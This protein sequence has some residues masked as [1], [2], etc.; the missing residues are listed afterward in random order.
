MSQNY[1][2]Q[3]NGAYE[4][5]LTGKKKRLEAEREQTLSDLAAQEAAAGVRARQAADQ[6]AAAHAKEQAAWNEVQTAQGLTSG[7]RGQARLVMDNRLQADLAAIGRAKDAETAELERKRQAAVRD[8]AAALE[9]AQAESDYSRTLALYQLE[10]EQD[11]QA[12]QRQKAM[13]ALLAQAGDYSLYGALYGLTPEQIRRLEE[14][15]AK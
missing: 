5:K 2:Q 4:A 3:L 9:E 13:A 11:S 10:K 14:A 7:A 1:M 12:A 6:R 8:F 15:A